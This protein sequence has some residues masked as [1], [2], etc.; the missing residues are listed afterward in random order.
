MP[1]PGDR[2]RIIMNI[3]SN[4]K[5]QI[6]DN[7]NRITKKRNLRVSYKEKFSAEQRKALEDFYQNVN[8]MP[9]KE[10][11]HNLLINLKIDKIPN[12][13]YILNGWFQARRNKE[14]KDLRKKI[15]K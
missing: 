7:R 10:A 6:Q 12:G 14:K 9:R 5:Y 4:S 8:K 1:N 15:C 2:T 3:N 13:R 11:K